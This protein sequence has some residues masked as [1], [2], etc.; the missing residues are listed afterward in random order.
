M[1]GLL[2]RTPVTLKYVQRFEDRHG[3][4]R[5]Y[6]RREGYPRVPLPNPTDPSFMLDYMKAS[7]AEMLPAASRNLTPKAGTISAL[8]EAYYGSI[9]FLRNKKSSNEVTRRYLDRFAK[10][11]GHRMAAE[12]TRE[13]VTK[14]I[15]RMADTPGAANNMLKKIRALMGWAIL[16]KWRADDP[17]AKLPKFKEGTHHTWNEDELAKFE[18]R[19]PIGSRQRT[20]YALALY[21]GQ[22]REDLATRTK[23]HYNVAEATMWVVQEKTGAELEIPVHPDLTEALAAWNPQHN[24]LLANP[25]GTGTSAKALSNYMAD[26]VKEAG[27]P[28]RCVLHGLRKAASRRL[29]EAGCSAHEI[30]SITGHK[31]L[32][33]VER[34]CA[35]ARQKQLGQGAIQKLIDSKPGAKVSNQAVKV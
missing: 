20:L 2:K 26:A 22:R 9:E 1:V 23:D 10:E 4:V 21:T 24:V 34:Y 31:S 30:M 17:T 19:W 7:G 6:Y 11:H 16:N 12:M 33:E 18:N 32:E 8:V 3:R 28:G 27:L 15:A 35:A 5:Y 25:N 14:I 29:A 13:H